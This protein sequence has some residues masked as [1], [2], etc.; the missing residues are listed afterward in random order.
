VAQARPL[1]VRRNGARCLRSTGHVA[2]ASAISPAAVPV[3]VPAEPVVGA[4]AKQSEEPAVLP[5]EPLLPVARLHL[6]AIPLAASGLQPLREIC[7]ASLDKPEVVYSMDLAFPPRET[8]IL[9]PVVARREQPTKLKIGVY[10]Q[11][12]N[13]E[14]WRRWAAPAE[15]HLR[16]GAKEPGWRRAPLLPL[17]VR[18]GSGMGRPQARRSPHQRQNP[19][20]GKAGIQRQHLVNAGTPSRHNESHGFCPLSLL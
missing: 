13:V 5:Q 4:E 18:T 9:Q 3:T 2:P 17:P 14:K 8:A 16:G 11:A 20:A 19:A 6:A 10:K 15:R 1:V 12:H 7:V